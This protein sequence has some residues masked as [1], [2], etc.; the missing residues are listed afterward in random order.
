MPNPLPIITA[1]SYCHQFHNRRGRWQCYHPIAL[2]LSH[3]HCSTLLTQHGCLDKIFGCL[4]QSESM[5]PRFERL[6]KEKDK[7]ADRERCCRGQCHTPPALLTKHGLWTALQG[8]RLE[9]GP[10]L[11]QAIEQLRHE[12]LVARSTYRPLRGRRAC[13]H[14]G[15]GGGHWWWWL[16]YSAHA[17]KLDIWS[18]RMVI[19][20]GS[21]AAAITIS[22]LFFLCVFRSFVVNGHVPSFHRHATYIPHKASRCRDREHLARGKFCLYTHVMRWIS[23]SLLPKRTNTHIYL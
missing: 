17:P 12:W 20:K 22:L 7:T 2:L 15:G 21:G 1:P 4:A 11:H 10:T 16:N 19:L 3:S 8:L 18:M 13:Q 14:G 6:P 5:E 9:G 23:A